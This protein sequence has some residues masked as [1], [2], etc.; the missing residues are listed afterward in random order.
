MKNCDFIALAS[1]H[2]SGCD[3]ADNGGNAACVQ[4]QKGDEVSVRM[5]ANSHVWA[6][7]H[8]TS[9]SGFLVSQM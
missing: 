5:I 4:L 2:K 6:D 1:D 9:F 8:H 3:T 7:G